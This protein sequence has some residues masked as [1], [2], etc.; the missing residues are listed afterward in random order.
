M[1]YTDEA[2][3]TMVSAQDKGCPQVGT[4]AWGHAARQ[5]RERASFLGLTL[6]ETELASQSVRGLQ[7]ASTA[8]PAPH[9]AFDTPKQ[10]P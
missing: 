1:R 5:V 9:D 3:K 4:D 2:L 6:N 10:S 8:S 7:T